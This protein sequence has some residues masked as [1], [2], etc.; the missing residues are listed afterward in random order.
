MVWRE[1]ERLW[2]CSNAVVIFTVRGEGDGDLGVG[3]G[4]TEELESLE[5]TERWPMDT[6]EVFRRSSCGGRPIGDS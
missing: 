5:R 2:T 4:G 1:V 3:E 6:S